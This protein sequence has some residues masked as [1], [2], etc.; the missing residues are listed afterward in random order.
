MADRSANDQELAELLDRYLLSLERNAPLD[1]EQLASAHPGLAADIRSFAVCVETLHHATQGLGSTNRGPEPGQVKGETAGSQ[2]APDAR[3]SDSR[4]PGSGSIY[5]KRPAN[6]RLGDF[7]IG[8]ELGRGG[9]G[10]VY[11]ANQISLQ[12][13]VALKVLPFAAMWDQKQVARFRNEARAAAQLHHPHIVPVFAVGEERGVHFYAMQFISGRSLD[14]VTAEMR[15]AAPASMES[16]NPSEFA[17]PSMR[18]TVVAQT[19][20]PGII[21]G[22]AFSARRS[23]KIA[24]YCHAVARLTAQAASALQYAHACGVIHRDI[25]PSNLMVDNDNKLWITDFGLARMQDNP[26]VTISGD[27][28]GTLRYMSPEQAAGKQSLVDARTDVYSLGASLYELLAL[29]PAFPGENRQSVMRAVAEREPTPLRTLNPA[30]PLDLET[31]VLKAMAKNREE[32]YLSAGALADDLNRFLEGK[33]TLARRPTVAD[34]AGKWIRRHRRVASLAALFLLL[35]SLLSTASAVL[36]SR[37]HLRTQAAL[38][39]AEQNLQ[40]A[41]QVVDRFGGRLSQELAKL[42]GSGP[43]R[44]MVL[45]DT[46]AY[47]KDFIARSAGDPALQEDLATTHFQ[48]GSIASRLGDLKGAEISFQ[49]SADLFAELANTSPSPAAF[50]QRQATCLN[51]LALLFTAQGKLSQAHEYYLRAIRLQDNMVS[52]KPG[53]VSSRRLL[54]E[55]LTNRGLLERQQGNSTDARNSLTRAIGLLQA[56][57]DLAPL[58]MQAA[59]DLA[60]ALNNRSFVE[61]ETDWLAARKSCEAA[62]TLFQQLADDKK[63]DPPTRAGRRSDLALCYNNLGSILGHL[64]LE[65]KSIA[66]YRQAVKIQTQLLRQSPGVVQYRRELAIT[67]NNL[68][69]ALVRTTGLAEAEIAYDRA[70]E[71][72]ARLVAD[73]PEEVRFRSSL[74]GVHNNRAMAE[75]MAGDLSS[76]LAHYE[77]AIRGQRAAVEQCPQP[78]LYRE[79][80]SK[81]Y[82][83]YGHALR[84]AG[85]AEEAAEVAIVRRQLWPTHS[86]HLYQVAW[87]L[88]TAVEQI[89]EAQPEHERLLEEALAT[90]TQVV[91][92]GGDLQALNTE[93]PLPAILQQHIEPTPRCTARGAP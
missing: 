25:K 14:L 32:R 59:R 21:R 33:P 55:M 62:L 85:R 6:K 47:Y 16:K 36:L 4:H 74:A 58:N 78:S 50:Q 73:F 43:L 88:A 2:W 49:T 8:P 40:Q 45:S 15:R 63:L 20:S 28:V 77:A 23:E 29:Q 42:P 38:N 34:R 5:P 89:E 13:K 72:F 52:G 86:Q 68:G 46:L 80:L 84:T 66:A 70:Q 60:L 81:H 19:T 10:V 17:G 44:Q 65:L 69:Q 93:R 41:R 82:T 83:N 7:E 48:S 35:L 30:I 1:I 18:S 75:E 64:R 3:H 92:A 27:V 53:D 12:R 90:L 56:I 37:A 79:Y 22:N 31:I 57:R 54:A 71:L 61:Q 39:T 51:N 24:P 91:S 67:W 76:A 26:G 9:M 11:E 87:E